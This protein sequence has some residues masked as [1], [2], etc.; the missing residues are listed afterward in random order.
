[1]V[2]TNQTELIYDLFC[3]PKNHPS[4]FLHF[5]PLP[6]HN[7]HTNCGERQ[8]HILHPCTLHLWSSLDVFVWCYGKE[9]KAKDEVWI[10]RLNEFTRL[11]PS[12]HNTTQHTLTHPL[13]HTSSPTHLLTH[14]HSH[15][16]RQKSQAD[17]QTTAHDLTMLLPWNTTRWLNQ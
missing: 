1:M 2:Q 8:Q 15:Y 16:G 4:T 13:T 9:G 3:V 11:F 10:S 12:Q 5:L 6:F 14:I 17:A 7:T